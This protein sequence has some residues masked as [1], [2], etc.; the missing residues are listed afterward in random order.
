MVSLGGEQIEIT[1]RDQRATVSTAGATLHAYDVGERPVLDGFS[2]TEACPAASGQLLAPW[3][4]RIAAGCYDFAGSHHQLPINEP[5]LGN[6]IHGLVRWVE[7]D[8]ER[9]S[10]DRVRLGHRLRA[11]PG[12]PFPL[13]L[14]VEY[15]LARTG[16]VATFRALNVGEAPCP[17]GFGAH[18]YYLLRNQ[19]VETVEL[20]VPARE[21]LEVDEHA[22]PTARRPVEGTPLDFREPHRIGEA[23]ID[24]AFT[25][26]DRDRQEIAAVT[27]RGDNEEIH[28][29]QDRMFEYV[30]IYTG[31]TLPDPE[32]RRR[33]VA[34]EP[35]TCAA[36]AFNSGE[37]L[38]LLYP[39]IPFECRWGIEVAQT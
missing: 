37:G 23:Q 30:Q 2:V 39:E 31:D 35:M 9:R 1:H 16:L 4:N 24:H 14:S 20:C 26:L 6:A 18:P 11:Q 27:L 21:W 5:A 19:A 34:V 25:N 13:N 29:W 17:F 22:I 10:A 12:Y 3:P 33:S 15:R 38:R 28:L 36:N 7:W 32:R 8:V